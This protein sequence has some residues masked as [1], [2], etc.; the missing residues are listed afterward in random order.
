MSVCM[1]DSCV[2]TSYVCVRLIVRIENREKKI[3]TQVQHR[4]ST[5][6]LSNILIIIIIITEGII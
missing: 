5:E 6:I 3:C 2:H 1:V 4:N